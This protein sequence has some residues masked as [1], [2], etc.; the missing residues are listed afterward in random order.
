MNGMRCEL[1]GIATFFIL[2]FLV[3][4][5]QSVS[6]YTSCSNLNAND[7]CELGYMWIG[8][9]NGQALQFF[10]DALA[11]DPSNS[12]ALA[13]K[14]QLLG[15]SSVT[16]T[17]TPTVTPNETPTSTP[18][19]TSLDNSTFPSNESTWETPDSI[20]G[21]IPTET[22]VEP[23]VTTI[24]GASDGVT[25]QGSIDEC[26]ASSKSVCA[27]LGYSDEPVTWITDSEKSTGTGQSADTG[28]SQSE[29]ANT[30][31]S[32]K[33]PVNPDTPTK[34]NPLWTGNLH[35]DPDDIL[36]A[37]AIMGESR[38]EE[39]PELSMETIAWVVKNRVL[40]SK[41]K[42]YSDI[43]LARNQFETFKPVWRDVDEK[44]VSDEERE[45]FERVTDP[46]SS[47]RET[48][49]LAWNIA[50]RVLDAS[51]DADPVKGGTIFYTCG[52]GAKSGSE[53]DCACKFAESNPDS[54]GIVTPEG[55]SRT[56]FTIDAWITATQ[57]A[58]SGTSKGE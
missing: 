15:I 48:W 11:F 23:P 22:L 7:C 26:W 47:D 4:G 6:G 46:T 30:D 35:D 20:P 25:Y 41:T 24:G 21:N 17:P 18:N 1:K 31:Q 28:T 54:P 56:F 9:D 39:N 55:Q 3:L 27:A 5:T 13:G 36:L 29:P 10:N 44:S 14:N 42:G 33:K 37:R 53:M 45:N 34:E 40:E 19:E 8:Q 52:D 12:R 57:D 16:P 32:D 49:N 50:S 43:I 51:P 58:H 2:I 38:G